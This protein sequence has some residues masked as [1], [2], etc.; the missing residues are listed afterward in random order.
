MILLTRT[1]STRDPAHDDLTFALTCPR[2]EVVLSAAKRC[3]HAGVC[4]VTM[5]ERR[6]GRWAGFSLH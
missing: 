1:P 3:Q 2:Q 4:D 5:I 6:I